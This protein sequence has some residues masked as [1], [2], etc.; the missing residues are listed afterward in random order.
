MDG[1]CNQKE[2]LKTTVRYRYLHLH[3]HSDGFVI[4][5]GIAKRIAGCDRM[6]DRLCDI[7]FAQFAPFC[8]ALMSPSLVVPNPASTR[9]HSPSFSHGLC[10][11][12]VLQEVMNN[13]VFRRDRW[14]TVG[15]VV[16]VWVPDAALDQVGLI[17]GWDAC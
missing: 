9:L 15:A 6:W 2:T 8:W 17:A 11:S 16:S 14:W 13:D 5:C 1:F 3:L 4:A 12:L 10:P 7:R